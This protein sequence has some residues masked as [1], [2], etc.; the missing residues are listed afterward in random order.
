MAVSLAIV[1]FITSINSIFLGESVSYANDGKIPVYSSQYLTNPATQRL[2]TAEEFTRAENEILGQG[3]DLKH[4]WSGLYVNV[5][6]FA[7]YGIIAYQEPSFNDVKVS[8]ITGRTEFRYLG[9]NE[10]GDARIT[11]DLFPDDATG[12]G[13]LLTRDWQK[14]A[15]NKSTWENLGF[16][17]AIVNYIL[18]EAK[19]I[20]DGQALDYTLAHMLAATG[21]TDNESLKEYVQLLTE[22]TLRNN[23]SVQLRHKSRISGVIYYDTFLIPKIGTST[24]EYCD[25][26]TD[27]PIYEIRGNETSVTLYITVTGETDLGDYGDYYDKSGARVSLNSLS[28]AVH[29]TINNQKNGTSFTY[30]ETIH[31]SSLS[32]GENIL[33]IN[34]AA[35]FKSIFLSDNLEDKTASKDIVI[36]VIDT[37]KPNVDLEIITADGQGNAKLNEDYTVKNT[38]TIPSGVVRLSSKLYKSMDG[39][40][41]KE[42]TPWNNLSKTESYGAEAVISYKLQER[43]LVN[44]VQE[45]FESPIRTVRII[46]DRQVDGRADLYLQEYTYEGHPVI[47]RDNSVITIGDEVYSGIR[48]YQNNIATNDFKVI[49]TSDY[50]MTS[51]ASDRSIREITFNKAGVYQ[52][53]L[54]LITKGG[55]VLTATKEI[56]VRE[57]PYISTR[58]GGIQ[59]ENNR[60]TLSVTVAVHP[61][62]KIDTMYVHTRIAGGATGPTFQYRKLYG[63]G[64]VSNSQRYIY[65]RQPLYTDETYFEKLDIEFLVRYLFNQ[66]HQESTFEY[67]YEY[68]VTVTTQGGKTK[69]TPWERFSVPKDKL[70][71]PGIDVPELIVRGE[72][73]RP[74]SIPIEDASISLDGDTLK[75]EW[76]VALDANKDGIIDAADNA[77]RYIRIDQHAAFKDNLTDLSFG[78]LKKFLLE[79]YGVGIFGLRIISIDNLEGKT[80]PEFVAETAWKRAQKDI[81]VE[82]D[83]IAPRVSLELIE[84]EPVMNITIIAE[85][86][87]E[88]DL[89]NLKTTLLSNLRE[90]NLEAN[91]KTTVFRDAK[92]RTSINKGSSDHYPGNGT[93]RAIASDDNSI[94]FINDDGMKAYDLSLQGL[95]FELPHSQMPSKP[96]INFDID[97]QY[98]FLTN[99]DTKKTSI[100]DKNTG[101]LMTEL[102]IDLSDKKVKVQSDN[103]WYVLSD[104]VLY[105]FSPVTRLLQWEFG[106]TGCNGSNYVNGEVHFTRFQKDKVYRVVYSITDKKYNEYYL[107]DAS[108]F[109]GHEIVVVDSYSGI[110]KAVNYYSELSKGD[111]DEYGNIMMSDSRIWG[112]SGYTYR[113]YTVWMLGIRSDNTIAFDY[114]TPSY[115]RSVYM[116]QGAGVRDGKGEIHTGAVNSGEQNNIR[117]HGFVH[118]ANYKNTS[119]KRE[120]YGAYGLASQKL[121]FAHVFNDL[122][123]LAFMYDDANEYGSDRSITARMLNSTTLNNSSNPQLDDHITNPYGVIPHLNGEKSLYTFAYVHHTRWVADNSIAGLVFG[124]SLDNKKEDNLMITFNR[125]VDSTKN[126]S[127]DIIVL[128][129]ESLGDVNTTQ[130]R[131]I[132]NKRGSDFVYLGNK[133]YGRDMANGVRSG[134]HSDYSSSMTENAEKIKTILGIETGKETVMLGTNLKSGATNGVQLTLPDMDVDIE[135][136][137]YYYS[138]DIVSKNDVSTD[139]L[140]IVKIS[141]KVNDTAYTEYKNLYDTLPRN[142]YTLADSYQPTFD[143]VRTYLNS[144]IQTNSTNTKPNTINFYSGSVTRYNYHDLKIEALL[145]VT[146]PSTLKFTY[147]YNYWGRGGVFD[148]VQ[149]KMNNTVHANDKGNSTREFS[150]PLVVGQNKLELIGRTPY[151]TGYSFDSSDY[152]LSNFNVSYSKT[153]IPPMPEIRIIEKDWDWQ[154]ANTTLKNSGSYYEN[155]WSQYFTE[156]TIVLTE[157][158]LVNFDVGIWQPDAPEGYQ[159]SGIG[160]YRKPRIKVNGTMIYESISDTGFLLQPIIELPAGTHIIRYEVED[161]GRDRNYYSHRIFDNFKT[162]KLNRYDEFIESINPTERVDNIRLEKNKVYSIENKIDFAKEIMGD[163]P[164][165]YDLLKIRKLVTHQE[166][167]DIALKPSDI[168]ANADFIISNFKITEVDKKT[169]KSSVLF[170]D[171]FNDIDVTNSLWNISLNG[172]VLKID[173]LKKDGTSDEE[174][175]SGMIFRKGQAIPYE[176]YYSDFEGDPSKISYFKYTHIPEL[177][178]HHPQADKWLTRPIER[179]YHDGK[180]ILEHYQM[181]STGLERYDKESNIVQIVFYISSDGITGNI[182]VE[183]ITTNPSKPAE[184]GNMT[185]SYEVSDVLGR[186]LDTTMELY[187]GTTLIKTFNKN[188]LVPD[189]T[190][191]YAKVTTD[192]VHNLMYGKYNIVVTARDIGRTDG[193]RGEKGFEIKKEIGSVTGEVKHTDQWNQN[194]ISYNLAKTGMENS[195]RAYNMFWN[196]ERFMLEAKTEGMPKKVHVQILDEPKT[197]VIGITSYETNL[198]TGDNINWS[199]SLWHESFTKDGNYSYI[200]WGRN[201][202]EILTFRF[203]AYFDGGTSRVHD[204]KI[205]VDHQ[206]PFWRIHRV[207]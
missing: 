126:T 47:A 65:G 11:N 156:Y 191:K 39:L 17:D 19:L 94:Y 207:F 151:M 133:Q 7:L 88:G 134:I 31:K 68:M 112:A 23:G 139:T 115:D 75:R 127:K 28:G 70:P 106:I 72:E 128:I 203:T 37:S 48:I 159:Y 49:G 98:V 121:A 89:E 153:I 146:E 147:N 76:W 40:N 149:V 6:I 3:I 46:D 1:I 74:A 4:Q 82:V 73:G 176:I 111:I 2:I 22:P 135:K 33:T 183:S 179:F 116:H 190:G 145:T 14:D 83:N 188:G 184:G 177:D 42:V 200:R 150:L 187:R 205:I 168:K 123:T 59:K 93:V 170:S 107:Y 24:S 117:H 12:D 85:E 84:K 13:K 157:P 120:L 165:S 206:D 171:K 8:D 130:F 58:L 43:F 69:S 71:L 122:G 193:D 118:L 38:T 129:D 199:G 91:I 80:L 181:D 96:Y 162:A 86:S 166:K 36:K 148:N 143:N 63:P 26:T 110:Q 53:K 124:F 77:E 140:D 55:Q 20:N 138:Y 27:K 114:F 155:G 51:F 160:R 195:P 60:Q 186:V 178:E 44:G 142:P 163:T 102:E 56:T 113:H 119:N 16:K 174:E 34:A 198:T 99:K 64:L 201:G 164:L 100:I 45:T 204:V 125:E 202:A 57:T 5:A 62:D 25:I 108:R 182:K 66:A 141:D 92:G 101:E 196:G 192:Q 189:A 18:K 61:S 136:K 197:P 103:L 50:S 41:W 180:Y 175:Q 172:Q 104:S 154:D 29:K 67:D 185:I 78:T 158:S 95:K 194:R 21:V 10:Y 152:H 90:D 32:L 109:Q 173:E 167:I 161:S 169:G 131:N 79:K 105:T 9:T 30:S 97:Y 87:K 52:V 144:N 132:I 137:D 54:E 15:A 81:L 35:Q